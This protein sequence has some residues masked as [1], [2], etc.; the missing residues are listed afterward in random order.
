MIPKHAGNSMR[1]LLALISL[2]VLAACNE[3][4]E[5]APA[6]FR[7]GFLPSERAADFSARADSLADFLSRHMGRPVEVTIP[8]AYEPL[9]ESLRL[10]HLDAAF[11]DAAPAWMAHRRAGAEVMLAE[12]R[13]DGR[14]HYYAEGFTLVGS[15]IN[16]LADVVGKRTAHTSWTGSSGFIMPIGRMI[17]EGLITVEGN[18]FPDLQR[19]MQRSFASYTMAGGYSA[20]MQLLVRGQ[21]DAVFGADD[22]PQRFLEPADQPR[23][24]SF[25][26][27]GRVPSHALVAARGLGEAEREA[28]VEAMLA[29]TRERPEIYRELYG[30]EGVVRADTEEHLGDFARALD[31]LPALQAQIL[32][33]RR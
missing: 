2:L 32:E 29:L 25:V 20:A 24:R 1:R 16:S 21:V 12:V 3:G 14:T 31:A 28:F 33:R 26:R 4:G 11:L 8:T 10:G 5:R 17:E 7:L 13:A 19:A 15:D 22:A 18:E 30:V 6:P 23:V 9:I 27:L